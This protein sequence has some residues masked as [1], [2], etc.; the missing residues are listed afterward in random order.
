MA[1]R[2]SR[3][4]FDGL[5]AVR[6][7]GVNLVMIDDVIA[8]ATEMGYDETASYA[9]YIG[10]SYIH[11]L[12]KGFKV[13]GEDDHMPALSMEERMAIYGTKKTAKKKTTK[14]KKAATKK[15]TAKKK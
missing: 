14:K 4:V 1:T 2:L 9:K 3:E 6:E 5:K 15:K 10:P 7:T 13:K 12:T 8:K 11:G